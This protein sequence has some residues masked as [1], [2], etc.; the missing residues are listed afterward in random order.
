MKQGASGCHIP[1][2]LWSVYRAMEQSEQATEKTQ[3][4]PDSIFRKMFICGFTTLVPTQWTTRSRCHQA[5][6]NISTGRS[7]LVIYPSAGIS[8]HFTYGCSC[9]NYENVEM[10]RHQAVL[11]RTT[12]ESCF[13][14]TAG[15]YV[16]W[17]TWP[18]SDTKV[19]GRYVT[20][21]VKRNLKETSGGQAS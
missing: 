13:A 9:L 3:R 7:R 18:Q 14:Y 1:T 8:A 11:A 19:A 17:F 10:S 4:F 5:P 21:T 20:T 15:E 6:A 2:S 16:A 12:P